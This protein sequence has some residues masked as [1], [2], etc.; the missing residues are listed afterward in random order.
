MV[1]RRRVAK[2]ELHHDGQ[3]AA[4]WFPDE[5]KAPSGWACLQRDLTNAPLWPKAAFSQGQL[6]TDSV[7][8]VGCGFHGIK[9]R[10]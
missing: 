10:A 6:L 7:E 8:K 3:V 2:I 1:N 9:V 5:T 4:L